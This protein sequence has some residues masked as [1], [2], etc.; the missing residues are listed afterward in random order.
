MILHIPHASTVIPEDY[1]PQFILTDDE[2]NTELIRMTDAFT[3]ELFASPNATIV[4]FPYSRLLV[5]VERFPDDQQEPMSSVGMGMLYQKTSHGE[6][7]RRPLSNTESSELQQLYADHHRTLTGAVEAELEANGR[8]FIIDCHSFPNQPLPCDRNQ[9]TPRPDF[10]IGTDLFHTPIPLVDAAVKFLR[11]EGYD[12]GID[13]PY[14]GALVPQEHFDQD[15]R[16][17]SIMI[18]ISRRLYMNESTGAKITAF[19]AVQ[20]VVLDLLRAIERC[21]NSLST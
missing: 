10:C 19:D 11:S 4:L 8:A 18:E 7:L 12:V 20:K 16:V 1:R 13:E 15:Q 3:H 21:A 6:D 17:T 14:A 9:N 2:L 5:D